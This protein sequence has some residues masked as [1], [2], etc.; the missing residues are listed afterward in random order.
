M[1]R[2]S[3]QPPPDVPVSCSSLTPVGISRL[4]LEAENEMKRKRTELNDYFSK[5][6]NIGNIFLSNLF[7][8]LI[9]T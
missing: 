1:G 4:P 3:T 8:E 9:L 5:Q 6:F 2:R 7:T